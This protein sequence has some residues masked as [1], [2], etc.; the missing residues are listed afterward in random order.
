MVSASVSASRFLPWLFSMVN[1]Y[2][3]MQDKLFPPQA[4]F[5][6]VLSQQEK[7]SK[8]NMVFIPKGLVTSICIM[9]PKSTTIKH[10]PLGCLHLKLPFHFLAG[11]CQ[12]LNWGPMASHGPLCT[13]KTLLREDWMGRSWQH[14]GREKSPLKEAWYCSS[15][16]SWVR[17]N[18]H[19]SLKIYLLCGLPTC[20][21]SACL[22]ESRIGCGIS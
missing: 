12:P 21:L 10:L 17:K 3:E 14:C 18:K 5:A 11:S 22:K 2:M 6:S 19:F 8:N 15:L 13:L 16:T 1:H 20:M 7:P 9:P 4:A